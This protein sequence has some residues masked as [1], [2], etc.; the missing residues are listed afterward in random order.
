MKTQ[1]KEKITLYLLDFKNEDVGLQ[2]TINRIDK[3]IKKYS[4]EEKTEDEEAVNRLNTL[5]AY[6]LKRKK[7]IAVEFKNDYIN[8]PS[9]TSKASVRSVAAR[10][11]PISRKHKI[12]EKDIDLILSWVIKTWGNDPH[13][14]DYIRPSTIL[15]SV[16]KWEKYKE[17]ATL[18]WRNQS[19]VS[20]KVY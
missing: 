14:R 19:N 20:T 15:G 6:Y 3:A 4:V 17:N 2:D 12:T 13:M 16:H 10:L 8:P 7:E 11:R 18:Y 5:A 9:H 1:L